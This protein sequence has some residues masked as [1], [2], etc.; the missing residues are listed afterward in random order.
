MPP[1][2]MFGRSLLGL[3]AQIDLQ[4][5]VNL[6]DALVI[7]GLALDVA[8]VEKAHPKTPAARVVGEP[9]QAV[10]DLDVFCRVTRLAAVAGLA[11]AEG[12]NSTAPAHGLCGQRRF[13]HPPAMRRPY[14]FFSMA[15][16]MI[17]AFSRSSAYI[18][19]FSTFK[20]C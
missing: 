19:E 15:S 1:K 16:W 10:G 3:E 13:V 2:A 6:V 7:S 9:H 4:L 5:A 8:Q 14:H 20:R 17:S 18:R 12:N 11:D